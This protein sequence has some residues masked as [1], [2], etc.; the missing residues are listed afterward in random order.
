M[1]LRQNV[2]KIQPKEA[3]ISSKII[4]QEK[5]LD[6]PLKVTSVPTYLYTNVMYNSLYKL[7]ILSSRE[8][9]NQVSY[10]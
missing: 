3:K 7:N 4:Y 10:S 9:K 1:T 8:A 2:T 5:I 6:V